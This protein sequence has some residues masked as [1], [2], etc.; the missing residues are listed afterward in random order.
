[1]SDATLSLGPTADGR[2]PVRTRSKRHVW[3]DVRAAQNRVN[4]AITAFAGPLPWNKP[5]WSFRPVSGRGH[6]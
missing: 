2:V 4:D 1:M 6:Q 3:A 5:S